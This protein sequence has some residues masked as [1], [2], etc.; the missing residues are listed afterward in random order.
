MRTRARDTGQSDPGATKDSLIPGSHMERATWSDGMRKGER[1]A[2]EAAMVRASSA[3]PK[4]T[5]SNTNLPTRGSSGISLTSLGE[6]S[7]R[8]GEVV[9]ERRGGQDRGEVQRRCCGKGEDEMAWQRL[10][11]RAGG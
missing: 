11:E 2:S 1:S 8:G 5:P 9:R 3:A 6:R 7:R 10:G 4:H